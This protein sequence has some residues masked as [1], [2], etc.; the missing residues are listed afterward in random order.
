MEGTGDPGLPSGPGYPGTVT[1]SRGHVLLGIIKD[2][3]AVCLTCSI[4]S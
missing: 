4:E 2:G 1:S 3:G